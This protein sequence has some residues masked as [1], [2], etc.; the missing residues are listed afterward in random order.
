MNLA[1]KVFVTAAEPLTARWD[2]VDY[3]L[4]K[5]PVEVEYG[6][7]EHWKN[8]YK[9]IEFTVKELTPEQIESRQP[10]NPLEA[11]DRGTAFSQ[12]KRRKKASGE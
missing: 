3:E 4:G 5:E 11:N 1:M 10:V 12:L 7:L 9:E 8:S 2:G 6:I